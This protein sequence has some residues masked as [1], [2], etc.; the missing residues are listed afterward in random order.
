M[1]SLVREQV[2][3]VQEMGSCKCLWFSIV[4]RVISNKFISI[5]LHKL[6]ESFFVLWKDQNLGADAN[7]TSPQKSHTTVDQQMF[8]H[9]QMILHTTCRYRVNIKMYIIKSYLKH[10]IRLFKLMIFKI[11]Y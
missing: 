2:D 11:I 7:F 1:K 4:P 3:P 6:N 8:E 10:I 9:L 5:L